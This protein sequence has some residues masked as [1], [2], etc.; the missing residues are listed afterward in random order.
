[1]NSS[2]GLGL[3][4]MVVS[5][6]LMQDSAHERDHVP[7]PRRNAIGRKSKRRKEK[8]GEAEEDTLFLSNSNTEEKHKESKSIYE[9]QV[10][11][12]ATLPPVRGFAITNSDDEKYEVYDHKHEMNV[13]NALDQRKQRREKNQNRRKMYKTPWPLNYLPFTCDFESVAH[14]GLFMSVASAERNDLEMRKKTGE[15][16]T[17]YS[18]NAA[19]TVFILL[20]YTVGRYILLSLFVPF[21]DQL[22]DWLGFVPFVT[23]G[24]GQ[25]QFF[26][27]TTHSWVIITTHIMSSCGAVF[28]G[29]FQHDQE[30]RNE[31]PNLHRWTGRLYIVCG[32]LM[33]YTA[34]LLRPHTSQ[35][36]LSGPN[37]ASQFAYDTICVLWVGTIVIAFLAI[38]CGKVKTH[39]RYMVRNYLITLVPFVQLAMYVVP[40]MLIALPLGVIL[41]CQHFIFALQYPS[42]EYLISPNG[43][44]RAFQILH[45]PTL[46]SAL[47]LMLFFDVIKTAFDAE[48]WKPP[49]RPGMYWWLTT[50]NNVRYWCCRKKFINY[51]KSYEQQE[52]MP[53]TEAEELGKQRS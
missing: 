20:A 33:V 40:L 38:I 41:V 10:E 15:K 29:L 18:T 47:F 35:G 6:G 1:M 7:K 45:A 39:R 13:I 51:R 17:N 3:L 5:T 19:Y 42:G 37:P 44:G 12:Q 8:E 23:P 14:S 16:F 30:L 2:E 49:S 27:E 9:I 32:S 26:L 21:R 34:I 46:W 24:Y 22:P 11:E 36:Y 28:L 25:A 31:L 53:L 4:D 43:I 48:I 52:D 50:R